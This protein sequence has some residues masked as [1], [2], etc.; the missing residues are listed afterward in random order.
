MPSRKTKWR[1]QLRSS[2][3]CLCKRRPRAYRSMLTSACQL[4]SPHFEAELTVSDAT[5]QVTPSATAYQV[6]QG[7]NH[8]R[9][10]QQQEYHNNP[11][12][13]S[14]YGATAPSRICLLK[15]RPAARTRGESFAVRRGVDAAV[16]VV[17]E[18]SKVSH[19]NVLG[20]VDIQ[21]MFAGHGC[22]ILD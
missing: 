9:H 7:E 16:S 22:L 5:L 1:M 6:L 12:H 8:N 18:A 21:G 14:K 15:R 11:C 2:W 4:I 3:P 10:C 20:V 19:G 17:A 13:D